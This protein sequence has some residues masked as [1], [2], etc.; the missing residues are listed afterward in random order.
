M[1]AEPITIEWTNGTVFSGLC[2]AVMQKGGAW[3]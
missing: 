3:I 1:A 2:Y